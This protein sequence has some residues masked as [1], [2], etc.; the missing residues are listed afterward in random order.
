MKTVYTISDILL[1]VLTPYK[2]TLMNKQDFSFVSRRKSM[3]L[4]RKEKLLSSCLKNT[5]NNSL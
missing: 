3:C 4:K 1:G 5:L 2:F